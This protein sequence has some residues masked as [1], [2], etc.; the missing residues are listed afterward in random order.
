MTQT[1]I[2]NTAA[3]SYQKK[4]TQ[5]ESKWLATILLSSALWSRR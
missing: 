4:A 2:N 1:L 3:I 5:K